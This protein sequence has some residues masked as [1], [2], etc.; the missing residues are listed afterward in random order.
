M[1]LKGNQSNLLDEFNIISR[2][3]VNSI[4]R[5]KHDFYYYEDS[6]HGQGVP[7]KKI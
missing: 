3:L 4:L 2:M 6:G 1:G 5:L 7:S